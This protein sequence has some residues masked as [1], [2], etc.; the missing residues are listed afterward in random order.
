MAGVEELRRIAA[1]ARFVN[2]RISTPPCQVKRSLQRHDEPAYTESSRLLMQAL[3]V[4]ED[5]HSFTFPVTMLPPLMC[6]YI[7]D[8]HHGAHSE[9]GFLR[10][11]YQTLRS[12]QSC[13]IFLNDPASYEGRALRIEQGTTELRFRGA[14]GRGDRLSFYHDAEVDAVTRGERLVAITFCTEPDRDVFRR[15]LLYELN[16][17]AA[18]EGLNMAAKTIP[19][20]N[21][22][23]AIWFANGG[24]ALSS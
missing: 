2:G 22:F 19:A 5:F 13:S 4:H 20:C 17:V 7:P 8:M 3:E 16:E 21:S 11:G 12:H 24:R 6:R 14:A 18:L 10:L 15:E 9:A 1:G 23:R